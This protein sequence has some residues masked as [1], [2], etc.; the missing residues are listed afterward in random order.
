MANEEFSNALESSREIELA[1]TGRKSGRE[2]SIPVW[3]VREDEELYLVPVNGSDSDWYKNVLKVPAIRLAAEEAQLTAG[4]TPITDPAEVSRTL[5]KFR[6]RY[7]ARDV[8]AY[9][10]K[11]DVAVQV[12][13][14]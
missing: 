4:A 13:L 6:A 12:R 2:I 9:Y 1:V 7:G 14:A 11:Q 3:F 5:D 8:A 10:P